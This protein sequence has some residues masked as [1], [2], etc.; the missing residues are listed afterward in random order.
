[1]RGEG[2][3][4]EEASAL[5]LL[6]SGVGTATEAEGMEMESSIA[7]GFMGE[8]GRERE[9]EKVVDGDGLKVGVGTFSAMILKSFSLHVDSVS[10]PKASRTYGD[11]DRDEVER[12]PCSKSI[13][14]TALTQPTS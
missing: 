6:L 5:R 1:V 4:D 11:V 12:K 8:E 2:R 13:Q 7:F 14:E 3:T 9:E 10:C